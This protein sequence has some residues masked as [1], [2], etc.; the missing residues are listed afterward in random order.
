MIKGSVENIIGRFELRKTVTMNYDEADLSFDPV[1]NVYRNGM[2]SLHG[3]LEAAQNSPKEITVSGFI[4]KFYTDMAKKAIAALDPE[5][6]NYDDVHNAIF[7]EVGGRF[8]TGQLYPEVG[9]DIHR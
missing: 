5:Q 2:S 6:D 8:I 1:I 7:T 9:E 4:E 3:L